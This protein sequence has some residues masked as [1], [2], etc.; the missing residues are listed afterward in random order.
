MWVLGTKLRLT[1]NSQASSLALKNIFYCRFSF[2]KAHAVEYAPY[3][4]PTPLRTML[5]ERPPS[6]LSYFSVDSGCEVY[7]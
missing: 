1:I 2:L 5:M 7:F 6:E 4:H 3:T